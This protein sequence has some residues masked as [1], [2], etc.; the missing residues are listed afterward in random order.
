MLPKVLQ[1]YLEEQFGALR[2]FRQASGGCINRGGIADFKNRHVF[3]KWNNSKLYPLLFEKESRGLELLRSA[4]LKVPEVYKTGIC[5]GYTY[6]LMEPILS[7]IRREDYWQQ[8]GAGLARMHRL[9][10]T[11]YGLD[12][13]NYMG[14][15]DQYN[16]Q[17]K[18]WVDFFIT[19]RLEPQLRLARNGGSLQ[20]SDEKK[21]QQLFVQLPQRL[22][23]ES[24]SLLHGD[25]WNGNVMT[26]S[27]GRPVL[28]DPAVYYGHRETDL[29][30]TKLFGGFSSGFY[31]AYQ[32]TFPTEDDLD[33][34]LD[35]YNLYPL[36]VH[37]NLFGGGYYRQV[38]S[39]VS[40]LV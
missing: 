16:E 27:D 20:P 25:L 5:E 19:R 29:A 23:S 10:S 35:I 2:S 9:S 26:D 31:R 12:H 28:I 8:L 21:F 34:R 17:S 39:I 6:I 13:N 11:T 24:P 30:M 36:L 38:M 33:L 7:G 40:Y 32:E 4:P 37:V 14:S 18:D 3:I 15:L 22:V 1:W